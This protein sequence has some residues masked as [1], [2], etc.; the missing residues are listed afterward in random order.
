MK[1][2]FNKQKIINKFLM[3]D[4]IFYEQLIQVDPSLSNKF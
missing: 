4:K 3:L 2:I 1:F